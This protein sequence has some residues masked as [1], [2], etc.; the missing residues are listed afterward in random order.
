MSEENLL[1]KISDWDL[2]STFIKEENKVL[3]DGIDLTMNSSVDQS[4]LESNV[5][6]S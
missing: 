6:D 5:F 1:T 3:A 2:G 4:I